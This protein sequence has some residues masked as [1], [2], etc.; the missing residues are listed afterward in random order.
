MGTDGITLALASLAFAWAAFFFG[1]VTEAEWGIALALLG[2]AGG[3]YW[4]RTPGG[5]RVVP[6]RVLAAVAAALIV[7]SAV[8]AAFFAVSPAKSLVYVFTNAGAA[9]AVLLGREMGWRFRRRIWL[10]AIPV[11]IV[12][13]LESILGLAQFLVMRGAGGVA[14]AVT[15]T[16]ANRNHYAGLLAMGLPLWLAAAVAFGGERQKRWLAASAAVAGATAALAGTVV[17]LSRMGFLAALTGAFVAGVLLA[18][19]RRRTVTAITVA[20]GAAFLLLP[21]EEWIARFSS[22]TQADGL[23]ADSRSR[24]W[25][26]SL[27]LVSQY[28]LTGT[29]MG[30]Y[31]TAFYR[32]KRVA[33][34]ATVDY[35]HNDYYQLFIELG[36]FGFA[37][38]TVL[39]WRLI[40]GLRHRHGPFAAGAW[41]AL[42]AIALH[43]LV[44]FNLYIPANVLVL[45]WIAG[46]GSAPTSE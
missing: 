15:G 28:A 31:E 8:Q 16:Y 35:V 33:P 4:W 29:G 27:P 10:G 36:G 14:E 6:D 1:G 22:I 18:G 12:V 38:L 9:L 45:G 43:S 44:D 39:G 17:S 46:M 5:K 19:W 24:I 20:A 11:L 41:G 37:L 42:A 3:L 13:G 32:Y 25:S 26:E 7:W 30:G 2:L 21:T 23:S 34:M 40:M